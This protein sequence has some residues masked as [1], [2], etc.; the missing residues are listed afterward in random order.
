MPQFPV[1]NFAELLVQFDDFRIDPLLDVI[2][3]G[4]HAGLDFV[5]LRRDIPV[6]RAAQTFGGSV[7]HFDSPVRFFIGVRFA[8]GGGL[9]GIR[10]R[11]EVVEFTPRDG[12]DVAA[13]GFDLLE[14]AE[15]PRPS[16]PAR[17]IVG[18]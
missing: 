16:R 6:G 12:G 9:G 15:Q 1:A 14:Q 2:Q 4:I 17:L 18:R 11:R 5:Q 7:E 10:F 3:F 8:R 13:G